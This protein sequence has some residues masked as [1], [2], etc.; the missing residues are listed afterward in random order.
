MSSERTY[1]VLVAGELNVD[2]ILNGIHAFP[3][4]G[5]EVLADQMTV[6]LG[7]SSAIFASNLSTL[8]THVAF[9]GCLARDQFGEI[10]L[11]SLKKKGVNTEHIVFTDKSGT[12]ITVAL[13]KNEDRAMVTYPG[14]MTLFSL[15]DIPDDLLRR[16][17]HLHVSSVFLSTGL[18]PDIHTLFSKARS[19]GLTTSLDPQWDPAEKWD[20]DFPALLPYV[21]V[22]IP[23]ESELLAI[24]GLSSVREAIG[25]LL[26]SANIIIVKSGSRGAFLWQSDLVLHQPAFVNT[27]VID[28]IGAGDSFAAGFIHQ[29]V[30][31]K[32]MKNC[33]E[34][35]ALTGAIN[36]T[37]EG[38]TTAFESMDAVRS[39]AADRFRF[40]V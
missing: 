24:T 3:E 23:N 1:D 40:Q 8:G 19:F 26:P 16:S 17:R 18:K 21:D 15:G 31:G 2:L 20:I 12:G 39:I 35:G 9:C 5:K 30:R 10:V 22:F 7:S 38:G 29:F 6:T 4:L 25:S 28:S 27:Q 11:A 36:T 32:D 13:N 37:G 34:F 14:A 33:L